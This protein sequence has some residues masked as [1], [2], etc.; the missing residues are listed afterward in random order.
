MTSPRLAA[1]AAG[2]TEPPPTSPS[3]QARLSALY[4]RSQDSPYVFASPI[5]PFLFEGRSGDLP[6]LVFFGP[7][8]CDDSW[9]LALLAGFDCRDERSSRALLSLVSGLADQADAGHGLNLSFFPVVDAAGLLFGAPDRRLGSSHWGRGA[10]PEIGLLEQD[11]RLN[12]YHGFVRVETTD[13]SEDVIVIRV[14]RPPG[15]ALSPDLELITTEETDLLPVRFEA[16]PAGA[17]V[18]DGPLSVS[19]DL[20][21]PPFE[22]TLGLPAAWPEHAYQRAV[23]VLLKRFLRR[24]RAFQAYG[25]HL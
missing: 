21:V 15:S 25:Q 24:Y 16:D 4:S 3:I 1:A 19:D 2:R 13:S 10:P 17:P 6:R 20:P 9:R 22:L 11:A 14:R 7:E 18:G 12:G 8:A 5:G 23:V